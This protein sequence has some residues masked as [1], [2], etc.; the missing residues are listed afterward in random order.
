[1]FPLWNRSYCTSV[2]TVHKTHTCMNCTHM[3]TQ[4]IGG[5]DICYGVKTL[6]LKKKKFNS[7]MIF[8]FVYRFKQNSI[9]FKVTLKCYCFLKKLKKLDMILTF[10]YSY[11]PN[12][13]GIPA[14]SK[15][16]ACWYFKTAE[17]ARFLFGFLPFS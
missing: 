17:A 1:M 9:T 15:G 14:D 13:N 2:P 12:Q 8:T 11:N 7:D 16:V 5:H 10:V 6:L 4:C 3:H